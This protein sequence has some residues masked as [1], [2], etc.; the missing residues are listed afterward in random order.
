MRLLCEV[1][2]VA[3]RVKNKAVVV[4]TVAQRLVGIVHI[5]VQRMTLRIMRLVVDLLHGRR[6]R[7]RGA[8]CGEF[9]N[10]RIQN[11]FTLRQKVFLFI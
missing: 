5:S 9:L 3:R 1:R 10:L 7:D 4:R 6:G 8:A 11:A 2:G